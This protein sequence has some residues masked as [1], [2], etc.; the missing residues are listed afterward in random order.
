MRAFETRTLSGWVSGL[1][2]LKSSRLSGCVAQS[3][4]TR[5]RAAPLPEA[6]VA[7]KML[8]Q[9]LRQRCMPQRAL[10][11]LRR[12]LMLWAQSSRSLLA[13]A[14]LMDDL[15][16]Q[17]LLQLE[18]CRRSSARNRPVLQLHV[19]KTAGS[20]LAS[21][22]HRMGFKSSEAEKRRSGDGPFWINAFAMPASCKQRR[23]EAAQ[24]QTSWIEVERWLD[25]PLCDDFGYVVALREPV[26]RTLHQFQQLWRLLSKTEPVHSGFFKAIWRYDDVRGTVGGRQSYE[27]NVDTGSPVDF[28]DLWLG[29]ATNYQ[30]RSLAGAGVGRAFLEGGSMARNRLRAAKSV[31]EQMEV[32]LVVGQGRIESWQSQILHHGLQVASTDVGDMP[33]E[34]HTSRHAFELEP[35]SWTPAEFAETRARNRADLELV[36]FARRLQE[37]DR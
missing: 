14:D 21:W 29:F 5:L 9:S 18:S 36:A 30:V 4:A 28:L 7:L 16:I 13:W 24:L 15:Y 26:S 6:S 33:Y 2:S 27:G 10:L 20:S 11:V 1:L 31:L 23:Q 8:E 17:V 25:L 22:G 37:L 35:Y 12:N 34:S 32:V 19:P 3:L